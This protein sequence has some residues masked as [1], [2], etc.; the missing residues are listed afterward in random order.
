ME[1]RSARQTLEQGRWQ[2]AS[3]RLR[4]AQYNL[5]LGR[6]CRPQHTRTMQRLPNT[7]KLTHTTTRRLSLSS[8]RPD[9]PHHPTQSHRN[10]EMPRNPPSHRKQKLRTKYGPDE[11]ML[12]QRRTSRHNAAQHES[13]PERHDG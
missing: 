1:S 13:R 2:L 12:P 10:P 9:P 8:P 7:Y 4:Q 3:H 5:S 11:Q 6:E